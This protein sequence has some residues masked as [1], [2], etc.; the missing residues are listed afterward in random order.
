MDL[1]CTLK[2]QNIS[3]QQNIIQLQQ[4]CFFWDE[5]QAGCNLI[6]DADHKPAKIYRSI[7]EQE[8]FLAPQ[9]AQASMTG[10]D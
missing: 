9:L 1:L 10:V 5:M 6:K 2:V 8:I 3:F 7:G 4:T